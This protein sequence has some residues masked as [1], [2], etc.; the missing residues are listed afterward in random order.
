MTIQNVSEFPA[1]A[2]EQID[3][4][5]KLI[6]KSPQKRKVFTEVCRGQSKDPKT[7]KEIGDKIGLSAKRVLEIAT[8]LAAHQLFEKT[9]HNG[10]IA[11][12]KYPN[13]NAVKHKILGLATNEVALHRHVTVRNPQRARTEIRVRIKSSASSV[14]LDVR[15]ITVDEIQNFSK[16]RSLP[17]N[18]V[19]RALDPERLPE[20]VFKTGIANILGNRGA[21]RDW[22][23]E[24]NDLYS[25][26]LKI[27]ARRYAAAFGFKGPGTRPPLTPG[28]MGTNG[29]QIQRLFDTDAQVFLV[30]F[31][32]E[33]SETVVQQLRKLALA[34]SVEDRRTV[35]YGVIALED[36]YR[37]RIK[38]KNDFLNAARKLGIKNRG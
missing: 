1:T 24:R 4:F 34:K 6:R 12:R 29:D 11:Y 22:G 27:K 26:H 7:A 9:N 23:G 5:A 10:Q 19:P 30:Q 18:K 35:F 36:S 17:H 31:E 16:V 13:I 14:F 25:T 28:K 33:I 32:G 3:H 21:F 37:L 20:R 38:Y 15:S 8:P 2:P